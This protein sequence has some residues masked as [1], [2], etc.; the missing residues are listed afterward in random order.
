MIQRGQI[1][2]LCFLCFVRCGR[3]TSYS[4]V[5]LV[6]SDYTHNPIPNLITRH[7]SGGCSIFP[8][9][10]ITPSNGCRDS[11]YVMQRC[12]HP[13]FQRCEIPCSHADS[14]IMTCVSPASF[15]R[16]RD[17]SHGRRMAWGNNVSRASNAGMSE[18][19]GVF[20]GM[21]EGW[22]AHVVVLHGQCFKN[23][24]S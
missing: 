3:M 4:E 8:S 9:V 10:G 11:V 18:V 5:T 6:I 21:S 14:R 1:V 7:S 24:A 16:L 13:R 12:T 19:G 22:W 17:I 20:A 23:T 15:Q 2:A